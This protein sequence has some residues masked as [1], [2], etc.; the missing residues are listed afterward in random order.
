[1][2]KNKNHAT[3]SE[4]KWKIVGIFGKLIIDLLF[5]TTKIEVF[6]V[7]KVRSIIRS[8]KFICVS[9]HSRLL[10]PSYLYQGQNGVLLVSQ[11]K[12][13][14]I[15]ARILQRQ[16][17]ETI[18]GSSTRGGLR[19][20]SKLI[21]CLKT[22]QQPGVIT[23]DGPQGPRFKARPGIVV[24]AR[25]TG[26]PILPMAYSAR[27]IKVFSSW[28]RFIAPYPFTTCRF[29][30]GNPIIV[31]PDADKAEQARCLNQ[32]EQELC[33]ITFDLDRS[34]GHCID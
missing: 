31:P 27:K 30:M 24:L 8:R 10:L 15:M 17:H 23:P 21:R 16:G 12:D 11:S 3:L 4:F 20:M 13:G 19:A 5:F 9:W 7:K 29:A 26:L 2:S 28:D 14:E 1:M 6:G 18:R 22:G 34:F 32:V 33:R 25:K